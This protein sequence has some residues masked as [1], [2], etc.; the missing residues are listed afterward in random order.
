MEIEF[1]GEFFVPG[2][3]GERLEADHLERYRFASKFVNGKRV[4]DIACGA[5]YSAPIL[6]AAGATSYQGVD[7]NQNAI[8]HANQ[9]Y[10]SAKIKYQTG[11]I[12][13]YHNA[14]KFDV[15]T[16]FETIE[17]IPTYEPAIANLFQ[18]LVTGGTLLVSSPYRPVTSPKTRTL[19]DQP[20]NKFHTQEFIPEELITLLKKY[21]FTAHADSVLGQ[22]QR[23][24][25][26]NKLLRKFSSSLKG[27]PNKVTSPAVT[28]IASGMA[29]RYFIVVATK[30]I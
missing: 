8:D 17:H 12:T 27:N 2:K 7:I 1:T 22:R 10:A 3:S 18:L 30:E 29:P 15:I 6:V 19:Q 13:T 28:K 24:H 20:S 25:Y 4:L 11:D 5:G 23:R 9:S 21:G 26:A 16:C 14:E